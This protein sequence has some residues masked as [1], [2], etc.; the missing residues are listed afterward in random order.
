MTFVELTVLIQFVTFGA[1]FYSLIRN[2]NSKIWPSEQLGGV[3]LGF[4]GFWGRFLLGA[5]IF[6]QEVDG[7]EAAVAFFDAVVVKPLGFF[8]PFGDD[9]GGVQEVLHTD[10]KLVRFAAQVIEV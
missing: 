6:H 1:F 10:G 3:V 9:F 5:D 4:F 7:L 8:V 2:N